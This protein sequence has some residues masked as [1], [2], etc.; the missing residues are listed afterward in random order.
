MST[1]GWPALDGRIGT[2]FAPLDFGEPLVIQ[3]PAGLPGFERCRRFVLIVSHELAPLSCL[4]AI[5]PPEAS[6]VAVDPTLLVPDYDFALRELERRRLGA[7]ET[8]KLLW[9]ALVTFSEHGATANLRAPIVINPNRMVGCQFI[10]E[11]GDHPV[12][13]GELYDV[14]RAAN[15]SA[16][17][18][19]AT[20]VKLVERLRKRVEEP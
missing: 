11:E 9:L 16:A 12:H 18:G 3:F 15:A 19:P 10:R 6:F 4:Q 5:D 17:D 8:E 14:I 1:A 13:K 2:R 7:S 20:A